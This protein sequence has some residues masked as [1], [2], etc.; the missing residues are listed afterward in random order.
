MIGH[1]AIGAYPQTVD[2]NGFCEYSL[3]GAIVGISVKESS[4]LH[5][6]VQ[7]VKDD[8]ARRDSGNAGHEQFLL[9][10]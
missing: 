8:A 6:P 1:Q 10:D 3:E 9:P 7:N 2:R 5:P 4:A